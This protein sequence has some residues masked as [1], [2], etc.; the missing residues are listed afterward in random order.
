MKQ[1]LFNSE[2]EAYT[3]LGKDVAD[4]INLVLGS[5]FE[6]YKDDILC[7]DVAN[8]IANVAQVMASEIILKEQFAKRK[9][10]HLTYFEVK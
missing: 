3:Q 10:E 1:S 9:T 2:T 6:K 8:V 5:I 7:R 4:H